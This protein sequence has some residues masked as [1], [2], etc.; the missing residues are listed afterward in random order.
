[1]KRKGKGTFLPLLKWRSKYCFHS[2]LDHPIIHQRTFKR[3]NKKA[4]SQLSESGKKW[5]RR[6]RGRFHQHLLAR[7]WWEAFFGEWRLANGAQIWR[8]AHKFGKCFRQIFSEKMLVKLNGAYFAKRRAPANF[9]LAHKVWWNRP[10][11]E[12]H[13]C[14]FFLHLSFTIFDQPY[15]SLNL[16]V[17]HKWHHDLFVD[18][19]K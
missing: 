15:R 16:G 1:M 8:T 18:D 13:F 4:Y 11:V 6:V 2:S 9:R 19:S 12:F 5:R 3:K 14:I 10:L 7:P 17:V